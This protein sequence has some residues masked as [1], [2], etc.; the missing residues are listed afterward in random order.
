M[1]YQEYVSPIGKMYMTSDGEYLTGLFFDDS[2]DNFKKALDERKELPIFLETKRW[3]DIYF[4]GENPN[5]TPSYRIE[6]LTPF[7]K[8]VLDQIK[9]IPYGKVITYGDIA[10]E[11]ARKKEI[12]KM[13]AQ[14]VGHAVGWNPICLI[15]PCHRVVGIKGNLVGYGGG[16]MHKYQLLQL[17]KIDMNQYYIPKRGNAL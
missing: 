16:I 2:R 1:Y 12:K 14:A 15:I 8:E 17:E 5:F 7:R 4:K 10:K 6:N 9:K 3:L 13:S 11:I